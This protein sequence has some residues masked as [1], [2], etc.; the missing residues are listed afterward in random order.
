MRAFVGGKIDLVDP[1]D[2]FWQV[3]SLLGATQAYLCKHASYRRV[4]NVLS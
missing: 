1:V 2:P 3:Y 4:D